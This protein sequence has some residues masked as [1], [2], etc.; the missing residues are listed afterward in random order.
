MFAKKIAAVALALFVASA[1][2]R[3]EETVGTKRL[4]DTFSWAGG[5]EDT[6]I[7]H[8]KPGLRRL[9]EYELTQHYDQWK[10]DL[11]RAKS[12]GL[13]KLRW[14][15]PWYR[16]EKQP[17]QFDWAWTD[18]VINYMV[19]E[20]HIDPIVDLMHY[21]TPEWM[22]DAFADPRYPER[23]AKY[24]RAFAE[25][26]K[27]KIT[28]YTPTNE[29]AVTAEFA[30]F[31][32]EWPPYLKGEPGYVQVLLPVARGI[33]E[34]SK[35]L[36]QADPDATLVAVEAM[37]YVTPKDSTRESQQATIQEVQRDFLPWDLVSGY[38]DEKHPLHAWLTKNGADANSLKELRDNAVK[39]D[40]FG[41]NFYPW[42][43]KT[44][45]LDENQNIILEDT[46]QFGRLLADVLHNSWNHTQRPLFIT[47]TSSTGSPDAR[48]LWMAETIDAVRIARDKKIPVIGY[49]WFPLITMVDWEYRKTDKPVEQHLL[50]LGLWD[51]SFD[52][53]GILQRKETPL[54]ENYRRWIRLGMGDPGPKQASA[55]AEMIKRYWDRVY[56]ADD[57]FI[58]TDPDEF[59]AQQLRKLKPGRILLPGEG[60]GRNAV[61]AA[62]H[63]WSV[64]KLAAKNK[65][66]INYWVGEFER[67][68]VPAGSYSAVAIIDLPVS[69]EIRKAGFAAV[70]QALKPGG[71]LIYEAFAPR[72]GSN[73]WASEDELKTAF[74]GFAFGTLETTTA[75]REGFV[76]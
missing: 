50:H 56:S 20:L 72:D 18:Q 49:T 41:V 60:E 12:L 70:R 27:D 40:I 13:T 24:A 67:L 61:Y 38:V 76:D 32:G 29:P 33:Q 62:K 28:Y 69:S 4:L 71:V 17:D 8:S 73:V 46:T 51:S 15:V 45:R 10:A 59:L 7:P 19:D 58:G 66:Q 1:P 37:R 5:I 52:E 23:V 54:V 63:G 48:A 22:P 75:R 74:D 34:I 6:F 30:G 35:A 36:R 53:K 43:I 31:K 65:V 2:C 42:S 44:A 47:E 14:G 21:G 3:A 25:R 39:Q 26:Y 16:V 55:A 57:Y 11:D 64:E 9:E 68:N